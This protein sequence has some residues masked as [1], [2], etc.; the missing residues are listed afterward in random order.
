MSLR[1][2]VCRCCFSNLPRPRVGPSPI[3]LA[4][5]WEVPIK[6]GTSTNVSRVTGRLAGSAEC[7]TPALHL[8]Y[9]GVPT[10]YRRCIYG[11]SPMGIAVPKGDAPLM[12]R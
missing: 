8:Y 10:A 4:A 3:Q 11:V 12:H 7:V 9:N 2:A 5:R 1:G 6:R